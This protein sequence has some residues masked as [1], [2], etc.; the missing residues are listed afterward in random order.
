MVCTRP[1]DGRPGG[2]ANL[3]F[4]SSSTAMS[5]RKTRVFGEKLT[6]VLLS[7]GCYVSATAGCNL[8]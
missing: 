6:R 8:I 1:D 7:I 5:T 4:V 3:R 2:S